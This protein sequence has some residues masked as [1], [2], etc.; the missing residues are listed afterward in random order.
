M[1]FRKR[2][3]RF[4]VPEKAV[5]RYEAARLLGTEL[6]IVKNAIR[7]GDIHIEKRSPKGVPMKSGEKIVSIPKPEFM[8][9]RRKFTR[10]LTVPEALPIFEQGVGKDFSYSAKNLQHMIKK[11]DLFSEVGRGQKKIHLKDLLR[12]I[13]FARRAIEGQTVRQI[14]ERIGLPFGTLYHKIRRFLP[15]INDNVF[16]FNHKLYLPKES[17]KKLWEIYRAESSL[18]NVL[19]V[20]LELT[21]HGLYLDH[22]IVRDYFHAGKLAGRV[23][24]MDRRIRFEPKSVRDYIKGQLKK[25][26]EKRDFEVRMQQVKQNI[27]PAILKK[28]RRALTVSDLN[29]LLFFARTDEAALLH[30]K[31]VCRPEIQKNVYHDMFIR[32]GPEH[33][34][35]L[36]FS[37]LYIATARFS[38][39]F[40]TK[41][42]FFN[43]VSLTI[44]GEL[45]NEHYPKKGKRT[46]LF[47]ALGDKSITDLGIETYGPGE[48]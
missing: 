21:K 19:Q 14:A 45:A 40:K 44:F 2:L 31:E 48:N 23:C 29:A 38:R 18:L 26:K 28:D 34:Q 11:K 10:Y 35:D 42:A 25:K 39:L 4:P 36:A 6:T 15:E 33:N 41:A 3:V 24:K 20:Q 16:E 43:Y 22:T 9:L 7:R 1:A 27:L 8:K 37:G 5:D 12:L 47:S 32:K 17:V 46:R 30:L 13:D